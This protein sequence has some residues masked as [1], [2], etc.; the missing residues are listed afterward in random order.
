MHTKYFLFINRLASRPGI[1][2]STLMVAIV[3]VVPRQVG[4]KSRDVN[5]LPG[6]ALLGPPLAL[7]GGKIS[8]LNN[9]RVLII[10]DSFWETLWVVVLIS[11][12]RFFV[13]AKV[14][15]TVRR[16]YATPTLHVQVELSSHPTI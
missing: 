15:G 9:G 12:L 10:H 16:V 13:G 5:S 1:I 8:D 7:P 11:M 2:T 4:I 3:K 14:C 6:A